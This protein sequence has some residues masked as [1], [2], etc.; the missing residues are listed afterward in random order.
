MFPIRDD[1]PQVL[2]PVATYA[3]VAANLVFW[4]FVQGAG[5]GAALM[6]SVCRLGLIPG[7]LLQTIPPGT[8]LPMGPGATCVIGDTAGWHTAFT[9]MFM[10]G[11][12]L[13]L[14]GN[15]WFLWIFGDNVED[16]MGHTRFALFYILCGLSA[17][18]VQVATNPESPVPMVGASGAIGGVM[19]AY[20]LL[21]P[22]VRVHML[23]FL[24]FFIT[25]IAVPAVLMLGYWFLVQFAS[26]IGT[27]GAEGG[28]V[29]FW[30]HV[31]G[32]GAGAALVMLFRDRTLLDRHPYHG[33]GRSSVPTRNWRKVR[34]G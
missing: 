24:G 9:S 32:F 12:W 31:G 34:R 27:L 20:V 15:M 13:H 26:G 22:R 21:F 23:V 16:A 17:A 2:T 33:W 19:G 7:E 14:I 8:S 30:A 3:I 25:T 28:G 11:G 4:V 1:N 18:A 5:S 6:S 29:A 10:H